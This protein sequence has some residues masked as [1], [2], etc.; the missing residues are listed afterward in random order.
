MRVLAGAGSVDV[1][2]KRLE[3]QLVITIK[4][5]CACQLPSFHQAMAAICHESLFN[6]V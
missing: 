3:M 6:T 2:V 4:L 5:G 1:T